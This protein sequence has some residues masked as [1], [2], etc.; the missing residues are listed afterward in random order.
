MI[1]QPTWKMRC[2]HL[3]E[4]FD[5]WRVAPRCLLV[6]YWTLVYEVTDRLLTWYMAL[7]GDERSMEAS[8]M[9]VGIFTALLGLGTNFMNVYVKSGRKWDPKQ[10]EDA[11]TR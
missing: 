1:T 7:P 3:A 2:M 9:A 11:E 4:C 5:A 8:G 10:A 6:A